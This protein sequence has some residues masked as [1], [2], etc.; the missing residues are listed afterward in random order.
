[1]HRQIGDVVAF[2]QDAP[3]IGLQ[4]ARQQIDDGGLAGAVRADQRVARALLDPSERSRVTLSP[5]NCFSRPFVSSAVVMTDHFRERQR[6]LARRIA[7]DQVRAIAPTGASGA[8]DQARSRQSTRPIQNCRLRRDGRKHLLQH[9]EH[10]GTIIRRRD[11]RCRR[12]PA[13]AFKSANART[14]TRRARASA[15]AVNSAPADAGVNAV[16]YTP[17]SGAG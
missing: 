14:R 6:R 11:S 13:P 4:H 2:K 5:P 17:R 16:A 9:L 8:A 7:D 1:M 10:H 15:V 3:G 12:S